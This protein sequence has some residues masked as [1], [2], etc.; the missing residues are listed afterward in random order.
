MNSSSP[1]IAT[2]DTPDSNP[3]RPLVRW[4]KRLQERL[5][6]MQNLEGAALPDGAREILA[7]RNAM[8]TTLARRAHAKID[9]EVLEQFIE[10]QM[11][12]RLVRLRARRDDQPVVEAAALE[13]HL[14]AMPADARSAILS[15]AEPLGAILKSRAIAHRHTPRGFFTCKANTWLAHLLEIEKG[16]PVAG[17]CNCILST[18][19]ELIAEIVECIPNLN[20]KLTS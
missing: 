10:D 12:D 2:H 15:G 9:L 13:I 7:H 19:G 20:Q 1:S 16:D 3:L 11:V 18:Q 17:R 4:A 5:P 8:T 6:V 14:H